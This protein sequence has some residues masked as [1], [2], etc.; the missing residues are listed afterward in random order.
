[1]QKIVSIGKLLGFQAQPYLYVCYHILIIFCILLQVIMLYIFCL[2]LL[3]L[4]CTFFAQ[5]C[6]I[7]FGHSVCTM[8]YCCILIKHT[9]NLLKRMQTGF[10]FQMGVLIRSLHMGKKSPNGSL[11]IYIPGL[12]PTK[13]QEMQKFKL[14]KIQIQCFSFFLGAWR[15]QAPSL[16]TLIP[17]G[18]FINV[19]KYI[20]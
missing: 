11:Y 18:N 20:F 12:W 2:L 13:N 19:M 15:P 3:M 16:S 9:K 1:M 6:F 17:V 5:A 10:V 7:L 8:C 4:C 14:W